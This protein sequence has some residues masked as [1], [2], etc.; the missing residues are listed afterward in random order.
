MSAASLK[1]WH[2][3]FPVTIQL[4]AY[5]SKC[6]MSGLGGGWKYALTDFGIAILVMSDHQL[7]ETVK[8][9]NNSSQYVCWH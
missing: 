5:M 4:E 3:I 2:S 9:Y 8:I 1:L 7:E 6:L